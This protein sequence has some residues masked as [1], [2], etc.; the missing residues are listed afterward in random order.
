MLPEI[1]PRVHGILSLPSIHG[2]SRN[3]ACTDSGA[4][5]GSYSDGA[6]SETAEKH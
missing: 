1:I 6:V 5:G 4:T 2:T 3:T